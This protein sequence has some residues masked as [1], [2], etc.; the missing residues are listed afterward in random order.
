M[1]IFIALL[2]MCPRRFPMKETWLCLG[3]TAALVDMY[4]TLLDRNI[5]VEM[6]AF[7]ND[8]LAPCNQP[9]EWS[10]STFLALR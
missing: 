4:L 2:A 10:E 6:L 3:L 8:T 9:V 7:E 5:H 1:Q